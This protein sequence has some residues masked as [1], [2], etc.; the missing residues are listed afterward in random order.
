M[1]GIGIMTDSQGKVSMGVWKDGKR[2]QSIHD[3]IEE[4]ELL[5]P[6]AKQ[7]I[8][9][10]TSTNLEKVQDVLSNKHND[11]STTIMDQ[12]L[13]TLSPGSYKH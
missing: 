9:Q 11:N 8:M 7:A 13:S 4:S 6:R 1:N 3:D 10:I 12:T 2:L 5:S